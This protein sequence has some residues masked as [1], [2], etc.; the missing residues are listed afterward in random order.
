MQEFRNKVAVITGGASGI[1]LALARRFADEGVKLVLGDI[2]QGPLDEAVK[3]LEASGASATSL[4]I[5]VRKESDIEALRD[6][7]L[8]T[9][10]K[11]HLVVNNA[12]VAPPPGAIWELSLA[13][14]QWLMDVNFYGVLH[15]CRVFAP[16]LLDQGEEA[17]IVNT[18][19]LAGWITNAYSAPYYASKFAVVALSE[20]M[21]YEM[22]LTGKPIGVSVLCPGFVQTRIHE[23]YRVRPADVG[24]MQP[25]KGEL[26]NSLAAAMGDM[27]N[28]GMP[29]AEFADQ[30]FAAIR[31]NQFYVLTHRDLDEMVRFRFE[32]A[33][34]RRNPDVSRTLAGQFANK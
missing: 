27:V 22:Q 1:G 7:A 14:W 16:L 23:S 8:N 13:D 3:A 17:H 6:H 34:A 30:V 2:E 33:L 18:A 4:V 11:V 15:G 26:Q 29:A 19:S 12:G 28:Q 10:G 25:L 31:D 32:N 20:A 24:P 5:D 21:F 9:F